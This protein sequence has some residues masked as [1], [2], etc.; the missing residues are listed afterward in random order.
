MREPISGG[1]V[2]YRETFLL[3]QEPDRVRLRRAVGAEGGEPDYRLGPQ[4]LP[5][6]GG[7]IG[8]LLAR[9][10]LP[11]I[12]LRETCAENVAVTLVGYLTGDDKVLRCSIG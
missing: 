3:P 7:R 8:Q 1:P 12:D 5:D 9:S 10:G 6:P 2:V 4:A 11:S